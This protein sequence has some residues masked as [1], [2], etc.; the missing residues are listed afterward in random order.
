MLPLIHLNLNVSAPD[1]SPYA[2]LSSKKL[3]S[4]TLN[5]TRYSPYTL[6]DLVRKGPSLF[7]NTRSNTMRT[8]VRYICAD[9]IIITYKLFFQDSLRAWLYHVQI[10]VPLVVRGCHSPPPHKIILFNLFFDYIVNALPPCP[11]AIGCR[12]LF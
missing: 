4:S 5:F 8:V 10:R 2:Y 12:F 1:V 9:F 6:Q 3:S 11:R 7:R